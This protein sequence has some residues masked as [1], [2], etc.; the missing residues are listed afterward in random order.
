M[1]TKIVKLGINV[2]LLILFSSNGISQTNV[3]M[4]ADDY[5]D[6]LNYS[7][8]GVF[9]TPVFYKKAV[10]FKTIGDIDIVTIPK[11]GFQIGATRYFTRTKKWS[12]NTGVALSWIPSPDFSYDI[13]NEIPEGYTYSNSE[14]FSDKCT[15]LK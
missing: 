6:F 11:T 8:W 7:R 12:F 9:V 13:T 15:F 14:S 4:G 10:I 3:E 1:K 2:L 5:E